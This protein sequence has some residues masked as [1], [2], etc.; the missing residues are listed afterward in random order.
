MKVLIT[1]ATGNLGSKVVEYLLA[2]LSVEEVVVGVRDDKSQKAMGYKKKGLEV[3]VADFEKKATLITAFKDIDRVFVISTFGD[4]ET[5]MRQHLNAVEAAKETNVKQIIYPSVTRSEEN[6]FFLAVLHRAREIAIIESGIPYVILRNNWY[7]ENELNTIQGCM[8]GAPWVTSAG[9][10][11]IGWVY[12]PD[13]AEA[14]AN[15][16]V[17][18]GHENNIYELSGENLTHQQFVDILNQV[19]GK[20]VPLVAVDDASF[21][22]MLKDAGVPE[23]Y[24]PML[25]MT[26]KGIREGG[27]ESTHSD[28]EFLLKRPATSLRQALIKLLITTK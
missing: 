14:A 6:D 5:V 28:L 20:E 7:I 16:L 19:T 24:H 4:Y 9:E 18:D 3:R 26:Q 1:G 27:L 11:K 12:R 17:E 8:D 2:K 25:V 10:G 13:L 21:E 15:I 22:K 23:A